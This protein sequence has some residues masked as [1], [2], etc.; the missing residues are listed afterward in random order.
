MKARVNFNGTL[1]DSIDVDNSVKQGDIDAPTLFAIYFAVCFCYAFMPSKTAI[2]GFI[3]DLGHP[4]LFNLWR[5]ASK[6]KTFLELVRELLYADYA[7]I[8]AHSEDDIQ[9]ILDLFSN[10]CSVFG[11]TIS[12]KKTKV[13]YIHN[14]SRNCLHFSGYNSK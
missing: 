8:V 10:A 5:L 2:K 11:L 7:D 12:L 6:T 9:T 14:I 4:V 13:I 1:S 3:Y